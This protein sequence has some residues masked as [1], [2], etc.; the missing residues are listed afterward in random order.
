MFTA[1]CRVGPTCVAVLTAACLLGCAP[2]R[3]SSGRVAPPDWY[4]ISLTEIE[5]TPVG[6]TNAYDI[7]RVLRPQMLVVRQR[8]GPLIERSATRNDVHAIR[9]Y[10]DDVSVGGIEMLRTVSKDAIVGLQ[11]LS[12]IDA[13]TRYGG[14]HMAGA[15]TVTTGA[16]R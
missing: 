9:V 10:I 4:Q 15:I 13:T 1:T 3:V 11:W 6:I 8:L 7:V 14:G 5:Q 16:H 2:S 12:A